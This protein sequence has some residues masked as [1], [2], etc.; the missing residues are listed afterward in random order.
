MRVECLLNARHLL[1]ARA[2]PVARTPTELPV[3][4]PVFGSQEK[5]K[6]SQGVENGGERAY[7]RVGG[8]DSII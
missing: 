5:N 1:G 4:Q 2:I 6:K 3:T 8:L 7:E